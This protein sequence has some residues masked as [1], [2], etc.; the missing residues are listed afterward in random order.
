MKSLKPNITVHISRRSAVLLVFLLFLGVLPLVLSA[1]SGAD[2]SA[3]DCSAPIFLVTSEIDINDGACNSHCSLREAI[4]AANTCTEHPEYTVYIPP[5]TFELTLRG[6]GGAEQ[7][8]LDIQR[9]MAIYG[10]TIV[11]T[12][13]TD[14]ISYTTYDTVPE[15]DVTVIQGQS[16]WVYRIFNVWSG[17]SLTMANLTVRGGKV[18]Q[19]TSGGGGINN[20][21]ELGLTNVAIRENRSEWNGGGLYNSG[22]ATLDE[23]L[24]TE[25]EGGTRFPRNV[26]A[27]VCGGGIFNSGRMTLTDSGVIDNQSNNGRGICNGEG[28]DLSILEMSVIQD[29]G[30][31]FGFEGY[32]GGIFNRGSRL[33]IRDSIITFNQAGIGGGIFSSTG[34]NVIDNTFVNNNRARQS[35]GRTGGPFGGSGGG[36]FFNS[37]VEFR[38]TGSNILDNYATNK[39]AGAY[40]NLGAASNTISNTIEQTA[41]AGN[42]TDSGEGGGIYLEN[43]D[44]FI[45]N[46]TLSENQ[47]GAG[48][49]LFNGLRAETLLHHVTIADNDVILGAGPLD[50]SALYNESMHSLF[51]RNTLIIGNPIACGGDLSGITSSRGNYADDTACGLNGPDDLDPTVFAPSAI[52]YMPLDNIDGTYLHILL[53]GL[54]VNPAID[55]IPP[56]PEGF[57]VGQDQRGVVRHTGEGCEIGAYE[58]DAATESITAPLLIGTP[59]PEADGQEDDTPAIVTI[60]DNARCRTG[61][62]FVYADYEF[63]SPGDSSL[64][65][66]RNSAADWLLIQSIRDDGQCWIGTGVI[67][68][69]F[70][71]E[72]LLSL[73]VITSPPTPTPTPTNTPVPDADGGTDNQ[74]PPD[75]QGGNQGGS[76]SPPAAPQQA[77]V[78][79]QT[80]TSQE[81]KVKLAWSDQADDEDGYR[82][83]RDGNLIATLG[84]NTQEY[85][86]N[87]PY[88]GPYAYMI[89]AFN[90]A[91]TNSTTTQDPGCLP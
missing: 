36:L 71:E 56:S 40:I 62:D 28:G 15:R 84:A 14:G 51:V 77:Y 55:F 44:V 66:G 9:P 60:T 59:T 11:I 52:T 91:G 1:C 57:C 78:A 34:Y 38:I 85:T 32:G 74:P 5:G 35:T 3:T 22:N 67:E 48:A 43:G 54:V 20:A 81:Y 86:D 33:I 21:G 65:V 50:S 29:N 18:D 68:Y 39:G 63:F 19:R 37:T 73:P 83:Y 61:P 26:N 46:S 47:A 42:E 6:P 23:V 7:G 27:N 53:P 16:S 31:D 70:P 8:D 75:N 80:C 12:E 79:N 82:I 4:I 76:S 49:A 17:A 10:A 2:T 88:G 89:E 64:A 13:S 24:V 90:G 30:S 87:P 69:G 41:I 25:N 72:V 45:S 58:S